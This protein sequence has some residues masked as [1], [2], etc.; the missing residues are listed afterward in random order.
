MMSNKQKSNFASQSNLPTLI[1]ACA[2]LSSGFYQ[3]FAEASPDFNK[4][5]LPFLPNLPAS[6]Q[7]GEEAGGIQVGKGWVTTRAEALSRHA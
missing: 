4:K 6:V 7:L 5:Q 1:G 2:P 3:T